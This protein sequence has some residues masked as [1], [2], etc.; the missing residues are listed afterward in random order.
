MPLSGDE[1]ICPK[2]QPNIFDPS[3][4]HDCLRQR[5]LHA[6]AGESAEAAPK[7]KSTPE[8]GIGA[9]IGTDVGIGSGKGV[10]LTPIPSQE[11]E[12][13]TSSKEDSD[14][15]S[16]VSSYCDVNGGCPGYGESSLCIL[17][18]DCELYICD[19]DDDSTDSGR[20]YQEFSGSVSAEDEYLPIR[21]RSTKLSMTRLDPPPHRPNPRAWMDEARSR[22]N[23][24]SQS[25]LKENRQKRES[26]YFS[27]GRAAGARSLQDNSPPAPYRHFER[28]HP[29]FSR[30]SIEPKDTIPFRNPNLGVAS[31]RLT[32]DTLDEDLP[33]EIPP[34]DPYEIAV[35]VEAQVGPRSPSPTP[36][37]IAESLASTGRK[38]F[39]SS[40]G[41]GNTSS[42]VSSYQQS[43]RL[44]SSRQAF[45]LQSRSSSPSR[46]NLPFR[47]SESVASLSRHNFDGGGGSQ[48][49]EPGS[50]NSLQSAHGRRVE[51]GTLPRNFKSFAG[52]VTNQSST[53]S[54]FRSALK[55]TEVSGSVSRGGR[56][57]R[58]A[59]PSRRDFNPSGQMSLR[60]T[61]ITSTSSHGRGRN[62]RTSSPS[63]RTSDSLRDNHKY[64]PPRRNCSSSSQSPLR[65]SESIM[66]LSR[67]SHHGRCGSPIREGYDIESQVLLRNPTAKNE[68]ND[69]E[70]ESPTVSPPRRGYDTRHSALRKTESSAVSGSRG[71]DSRCSS[72]GRRGHETPTQYQRRETDTSGSLPGRS[73]ESRHSSPSRRSHEAPSQSLLRKSETIS[74]V[75]SRDGHSL[76]PSRKS[77]DAPDQRSLRRTETSS[78]LNSKNHSSRNSS[79]AKKGIIDAPGYSILRN[80]TNG[81]SSHSFQRKNTYHDSKSDS[82]R[83]PRSW[84]ESTS[85]LHS[86]SLS[87]AASPSRQTTN[88]SK[89][90]FVTLDTPRNPGGIRSGVGRRGHDDH[91]PSPNDKRPS[92]RTRSHSPSPQIETRRHTSSQSSMESSESG[93]LSVGS[94][95]RNR[96]EYAMI[97]DV[98]KVKIIHQREEPGHMR[99]PQNQQPSRRQELYKPAS[100]SLSKHPSREWEDTGDTERDWHY[101]YLSRAHSSTSLQRSGS[102]TA[103]EGSSWKGNQHR[104]EHMQPDLLNFKKGWMSKLDDSGEW[105]KHWFVLTDAGLKYYRD[106]SAEE[107]DDLDGEIDLKSCVKVCEFD[108]EKNYGFQVQTQEAAHTLSAMTAG[109]RRNWIEVLK[110]C[111]RPSSSPDLT[112]LPDGSS[113]KENSHSR[114]PLSSRRPSSRHV[115]VQSEIPTPASPAHRRFD[116]VELSPVPVLSSPLPATQREAAEGQGREHSQWQEERNTSSQWEAVL[117]RKGTGGGSNQRLRTEE[118]I[119]R[120][121]AEFE[122]L[123]LKAMSSLPPMGSRPSGQSANEALQREVVASLRQ[124]LEQLQGGGGGGGGRW[125]GGVRGGCGPEAPCGRSL[126]AM[127][128]AH[129][130]VLDELQRQHDR[131]TKELETERD[132]LLLEETKDTA[133]VMEA[134]KKK[135]KDELEREVERVKRLSSGGLDSQTVRAHQQAET[136]ALQREL[137]GLSERYSQKCLELNRAEQNN[138]ERERE[139]S[140]KERDMEQLRKENQDIKARLKEEMSRTQSTNAFHGSEHNK[141][142]T[143]CELE[144]LLR[145]KENE[146]EYLHKEISCLRNELQ[147]LN[148]E[149]RLACE[150]Y[151]QVHEELSGMKGRS[152]R[153]IQSLKEH[154]KLAMAAL[155]EGQKLGNS[156]DH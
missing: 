96:E 65:K 83:S 36:F 81:D 149:N 154:L 97:A 67:R 2:F 87:R 105:K 5:H 15:L 114:F 17:S 26:G 32:P 144:V 39:S 147:F 51:S 53:V 66:S 110:K 76:L 29:I 74:S 61:E 112:Q 9:K 130:Q 121:W 141:D 3:R 140:R 59:S 152:E 60:K 146:I 148:T 126:A 54:D 43:G 155:Q 125:G 69:H 124:Q 58:S 128:R 22:D 23:F 150:R 52:S 129:R 115:D 122:R 1:P 42:H 18:P 145:V 94:T 75:K 62:S 98:P 86:S 16:V 38:G 46:G 8:A 35:E 90:A 136:Q 103:D 49:T 77:Y 142:R 92:N 11:E 41:R 34:P 80:A 63:R 101:G 120:K 85:S 50:R 44:E 95:G 134:L 123:P 93:Q 37:K 137:A 89:T 107:K 156:L 6:G 20:D 40:Y 143:P 28:G 24:S 117:S 88:G 73:R 104:S 119:E 19:G 12:R 116:Y 133:R 82:N 7:Q 21:R 48:R 102:P 72:P 31:E 14:G 131:Q 33:E 127:E 132:R 139:I 79:L 13:D 55:K 30:R 109:I 4:C 68:L 99:G 64:S 25:G 118:E 27:L 84:R 91:C 78:S 111:I 47:R 113:D 135:H 45:A 71:H 57:S 138:A 100:H 108:V 151:T 10:L 106:S 70:H 153:E 56:D